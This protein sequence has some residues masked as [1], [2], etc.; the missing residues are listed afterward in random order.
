MLKILR[1]SHG[2]CG[3]T[4]KETEGVDVVFDDGSFRGFLS[5]K[6][7]QQMVQMK[8]SMLDRHDVGNGSSREAPTHGS[9]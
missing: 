8:T 1:A 4:A 5:W 2:E 9:D 6:S 3:L 7:L